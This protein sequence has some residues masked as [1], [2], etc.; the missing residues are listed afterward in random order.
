MSFTPLFFVLDIHM[1]ILFQKKKYWVFDSLFIL[2]SSFLH[3][4]NSL[5][6]KIKKI[7]K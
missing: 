5:R 6:T 2:N 1:S 3:H 7:F 4:I